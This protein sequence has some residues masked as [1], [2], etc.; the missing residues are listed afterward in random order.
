MHWTPLLM[1]GVGP[2]VYASVLTVVPPERR[3]D[4]KDIEASAERTQQG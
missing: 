2:P 3:L 4:E 1:P